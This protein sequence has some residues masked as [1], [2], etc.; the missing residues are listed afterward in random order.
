MKLYTDSVIAEIMAFY[1]DGWS[2]QRIAKKLN[3][4]LEDVKQIVA[5]HE[6]W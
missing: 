1:W 3:L 4:P 6:G 2:V 5:K